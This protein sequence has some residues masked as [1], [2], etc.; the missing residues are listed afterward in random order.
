M[1]YLGTYI[2]IT[3]T[4]RDAVLSLWA[5]YFDVQE[6]MLGPTRRV[7]SLQGFQ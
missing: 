7:Y 3:R 6:I 1:Y 5:T 4:V 2:Y